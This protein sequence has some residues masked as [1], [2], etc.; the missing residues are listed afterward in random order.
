MFR[1]KST[2]K[3][4]KRAASPMRPTSD[5]YAQPD[6]D[7][8]PKPRVIEPSL[9]I[10]RQYASFFEAE[11]A[12]TALVKPWLRLDRGMR[13]QKYRAFAEAYPGLST[14][15]K[16]TLYKMLLKANDSKL[17]NTKTQVHYENGTIQAV[18]GL[19]IIRTG[20]PTVPATFKIE[21]PRATKR[22][23]DN[24]ATKHGSG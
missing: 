19:M 17:L 24:D 18:H 12:A 10:D 4:V 13:L 21:V 22:N 9:G 6:A 2:R 20:D 11:S 1:V 14:V 8:I 7:A 16:D 5:P 3:N 23:T 15:E